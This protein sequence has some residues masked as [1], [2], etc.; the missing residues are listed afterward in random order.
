MKYGTFKYGKAKYGKYI[1]PVE[2]QGVLGQNVRYRIRSI[3]SSGT[4]SQSTTNQSI[5]F[6]T[7]Q[8][9]VA[10]RIKSNMN[11]DYT[12]NQ[13]S[14]LDGNIYRVRIKTQGLEY[15]WVESVVGTAKLKGD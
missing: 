4:Q 3:S 9:P 7:P 13:S 1:L 15:P 2:G 14:V 11:P 12:I 10:V 5:S 8:K 6:E